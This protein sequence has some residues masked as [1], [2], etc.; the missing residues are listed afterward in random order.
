MLI[1]QVESGKVSYEPTLTLFSETNYIYMI[2]RNGAKLYW[3][4]DYIAKRGC[5]IFLHPGQR[6]ILQP[7]EEFLLYDLVQFSPN[8][9]ESEVIRHLPLPESFSVPPHLSEL[10]THVRTIYNIHFSAD[11]YRSEKTSLMTQMLLYSIASGDPDGEFLLCETKLNHRKSFELELQLQFSSV[12]LTKSGEW[13]DDIYL[14]ISST[15]ALSQNSPDQ[16]ILECQIL[17][18]GGETS[19]LGLSCHSCHSGT[20]GNRIFKTSTTI[21]FSIRQLQLYYRYDASSRTYQW[22]ATEP[23]SGLVIHS[24][25][26]PPSFVSPELADNSAANLHLYRNPMGINIPSLMLRYPEE[27]E[28]KN[29][30]YLDLHGKVSSL[31]PR[32][33]LNQKLR[34]L[35]TWVADNPSRD[36][37]VQEAANFMN[38]SESRFYYL[39]KQYFGLTF[40]SDVI[41]SRINRSCFLL[42]TTQK[43]VKEIAKC[44]GYTNDALFYRQFKEQMGITPREYQKMNTQQHI[45]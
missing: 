7:S 2:C 33:Q 5:Q 38:L 21:P 14:C 6:F 16:I 1:Y 11:K 4:G 40:M 31:T 10:S 20:W 19:R 24:Y 3:N 18:G 36:W 32:E 23:K 45:L 12:N 34:R 28:C 25:Q 27:T 17:R 43:P 44:V 42:I 35:R 9:A 37:T 26:T 30:V 13:S 29:A 15:D 39:Y 8:E 41:R 22:K